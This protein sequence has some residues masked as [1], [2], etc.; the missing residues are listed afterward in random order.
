MTDLEAMVH[1]VRSQVQHMDKID[2]ELLLRNGRIKLLPFKPST[3]T[4]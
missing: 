3:I 2:S 4:S 1:Y